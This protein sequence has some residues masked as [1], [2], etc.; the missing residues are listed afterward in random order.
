MGFVVNSITLKRAALAVLT[1]GILSSCGGGNVVLEGERFGIRGQQIADGA[2]GGS[3]NAA[4]GAAQSNA[5]WTQFGGRA[6]HDM[7]HLAL[8]PA[9]T[10]RWAVSYGAS[11]SK[12]AKLT[13]APIVSGGVVY[14]L[15][16]RARLQATDGATGA[17]YWARELTPAGERAI[18][19]MGGGLAIEGGTIY[20]TTGF[21]EVVSLSASNGSVNWRFGFDAP[22]RSG[23]TVAGGR[24]I[25]IT[26]DNDAIALDTRGRMLWKSPGPKTDGLGIMVGSP[27]AISGSS[28]VVPYSTGEVQAISIGNG[29]ARWGTDVNQGRLSASRS[30]IGEFT[31]APVVSGG[32]VYVA[33][34]AG[35]IASLDLGSGNKRWSAAVGASGSL[36]VVGNSVYLVTDDARLMRLDE[37][38]GSAVW[39]VQLPDYRRNKRRGFILHHGPV[40]AGG[41][42][43]IASADGKLRRFAPENGALLGES[44]IPGGAASA[45]VVAAGTLYVQ[46]G[47]GQLL[48]FQ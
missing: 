44:D 43:I 34:Q 32:R 21:G 31:G 36:A 15:D 9:P 48:A 30:S 38:N 45:P 5:A 6:D 10:L 3:A 22:F 33:N 14:T 19:G 2:I 12:N 18:S 4:L 26:R 17:V 8:S 37:A 40:I 20:A 46:S 47:N 28:V 25:A 13:S 27:A 16:T 35:E 24:I 7:P 23:P 29:N 11:T 42:V 1:A 41:Q 39:A